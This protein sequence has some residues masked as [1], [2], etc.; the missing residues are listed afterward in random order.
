MSM[1][2]SASWQKDNQP[3]EEGFRRVIAHLLV[4]VLICLTPGRL[5]LLVTY[6]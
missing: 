4:L 5:W 3:T 6:M 1:R 2:M